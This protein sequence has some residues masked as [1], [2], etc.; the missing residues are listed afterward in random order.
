M[1]KAIETKFLP[2]TDT[3]GSRIKAFDLDNNSV[4]ISYPHELNQGQAHRKA[5]QALADK[6]GW[7]G[8]LIGGCTKA[9]YVFV[10]KDSWI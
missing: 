2:C 4:T 1:A 10:F 8:E 6:M 3:K 7:T 9:G 5:A